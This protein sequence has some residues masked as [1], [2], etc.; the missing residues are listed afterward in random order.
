[1]QMLTRSRVLLGISFILG[2]ATGVGAMLLLAFRLVDGAAIAA[3]IGSESAARAA[4]TEARCG[5]RFADAI[6]YEWTTVVLAADR[7]PFS[8]RREIGA[9]STLISMA[10]ARHAPNAEFVS[11]GQAALARARLALTLEKAGFHGQATTQWELSMKAFA[12][13]G[14]HPT[15]EMILKTMERDC[16]KDH[17]NSPR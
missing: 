4:A 1:M 15:R 13:L 14:K 8:V 17:R 11:A 12:D 7:E 10:K 5:G 6:P 2:V 16:V 9:L 3:N